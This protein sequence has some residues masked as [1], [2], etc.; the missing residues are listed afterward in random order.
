[1]EMTA[2][3]S[4]HNAR[5]FLQCAPSVAKIAKYLS[6]HAKADL[7]IAASVILPPERT[8]NNSWN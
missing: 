5:C 6:N 7:S 1:M 8:V 4:D 2:M 3:A